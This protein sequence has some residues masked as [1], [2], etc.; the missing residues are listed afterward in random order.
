MSREMRMNRAYREAAAVTSFCNWNEEIRERMIENRMAEELH[1]EH[2]EADMEEIRKY[3]GL[4]MIAA[5]AR[6]LVPLPAC[7][8]I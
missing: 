5:A 6:K 8:R 4:Q 7:A 1:R 2:V 3:A